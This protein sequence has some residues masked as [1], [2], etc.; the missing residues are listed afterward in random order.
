MGLVTTNT[1][2]NVAVDTSP[3]LQPDTAPSACSATTVVN[4]SIGTAHRCSGKLIL[5]KVQV[6]CEGIWV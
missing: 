4:Q 3:V 5:S 1:G 6:S 2:G